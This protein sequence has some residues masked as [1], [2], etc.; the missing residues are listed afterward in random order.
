MRREA[1]LEVARLAGLAGGEIFLIGSLGVRIFDLRDL[2]SVLAV[3]DAWE[4]AFPASVAP[5]AVRSTALQELGRRDEFDRLMDCEKFLMVFRNQD[6]SAAY[7]RMNEEI[8]RDIREA[9]K[10]DIVRDRKA[11]KL[12]DQTTHLGPRSSPALQA[13]FSSVAKSVEQFVEHATA[14]AGTEHAWIRKKPAS[15]AVRA[16]GVLLGESGYQNPHIHP[17]AWMSGVYYPHL[18]AGT[19]GEQPPAGWLQI[20]TLRPHVPAPGNFTVKTQ[21]RPEEGTLVLF[22]SY[23]LHGTMPFGSGDRLTAAFDFQPL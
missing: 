16:W 8:A 20:G 10:V 19:I 21:V 1:A 15:F 3:A 22:P 7:P 17:S 5:L 11:T 6:R 14:S 23:L 12:G 2:Q 9:G 4:D 18:P 13:F